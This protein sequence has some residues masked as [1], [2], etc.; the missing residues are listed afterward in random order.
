MVRFLPPQPNLEHLKG[1]AKALRKAHRE[2]KPAVCGVLRH[3][4]RFHDADDEDIFAANVPLTEV[5]FALAME[6]GFAGW[7]ELRRAVLSLNPV[8]DYR[9]EAQADALFLPNPQPG[10]GGVNRFAAAFS[11]ALS[12]MGVPADPVLVAGDSGL[13]FVLQADSLHHPWGTDQK[14]LDIGWWPLDPWGFMLRLDFLGRAYGAPMRRLE[15]VEAEYRAD[16]AA[17]YQKHYHLEVLR[18]LRADRPVVAVAAPHDI[19]V[20]YGCDSGNPPLLGQTSCETQLNV[21]RMK[22]YPWEVVVL[23]EPAAPMDRRQADVEALEFALRL[24]RDEVDLSH[25]PGKL[26]G[27]R[28]WQLWLSQLEEPD[29]CGPH[30]YHANVIGHLHQNRAA[31]ASYLRA[32]SQRHAGPAGATLAAVAAG[33]DAVLNK[34]K[35]AKVDKESFQTDAGRQPLISLVRE[36]MA[37]EASCHERMVEAREFIR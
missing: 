16:S 5:Q 34:L 14:A 29:L 12:N 30:F 18:S 37:L 27:R 24:G 1:E 10:G 8:E 35:Q 28:A 22:V 26:S 36:T 15:R 4:R 25:L 33:Y 31:A 17:H 20:I 19:Y 23:G 7:A 3:L 13:A 21:H 32:M 9:P 11:L 6:Y 2:R